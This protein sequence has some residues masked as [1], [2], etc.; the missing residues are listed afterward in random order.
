MLTIQY[1]CY[2]VIKVSDCMHVIY[3]NQY[4]VLMNVLVSAHLQGYSS[5]VIGWLPMYGYLDRLMLTS[6]R[7]WNTHYHYRYHLRAQTSSPRRLTNLTQIQSFVQETQ[8]ADLWHDDRNDS[9]GNNPATKIRRIPDAVQRI[10]SHI[11]FARS[12]EINAPTVQQV[13]HRDLLGIVRIVSAV[14]E[15]VL[16]MP[17]G[18]HRL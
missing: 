18:V 17:A 1:R 12:H 9:C 8:L 6:T 16:A 7:L 4:H 5:L 10:W 3:R 13:Y 14:I 2:S 15:H 11:N